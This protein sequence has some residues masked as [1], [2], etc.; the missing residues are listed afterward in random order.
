MI[1][2]WDQTKSH[3]RVTLQLTGVIAEKT[4]TYLKTIK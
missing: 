3:S 1:S 2:S 4:V